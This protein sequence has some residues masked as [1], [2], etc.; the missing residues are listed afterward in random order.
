M[1]HGPE[2]PRQLAAGTCAPGGGWAGRLLGLVVSALNWGEDGSGA[3]FRPDTP[4]WN[5]LVGHLFPSVPGDRGDRCQSCTVA[6]MVRRR[7]ELACSPLLTSADTVPLGL[8]TATPQAA[9]IS[10]LACGHLA[11]G[12]RQGHD[13]RPARRRPGAVHRDRAW[14]PRREHG[15][16]V[17]RRPAWLLMADIRAPATAGTGPAETADADGRPAAAAAQASPA[18]GRQ[19]P[20]DRGKKLPVVAPPGS[21][22]SGTHSL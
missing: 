20:G 16:P 19:G 8:S 3:R 22:K 4:A 1:L 7:A 17:T 6:S 14:P 21:A 12:R 5:W 2:T 9:L 13:R 10:G 11:G 15:Q 18:Q